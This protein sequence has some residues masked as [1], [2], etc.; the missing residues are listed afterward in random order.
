MMSEPSGQKHS[1]QCCVPFEGTSWRSLALRLKSL[2]LLR[3]HV[4]A[5]LAG[6]ARGVG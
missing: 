4:A 2:V 5:D 1:K 3:A 6:L